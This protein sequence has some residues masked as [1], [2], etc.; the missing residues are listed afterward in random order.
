MGKDTGSDA[1]VVL[2]EEIDKDYEPTEQEIIDY[3]EWLGMDPQ[4]DKDLL[5]IAKAGLKAP[6]PRPWKP[7]QTNE[8]GEIFYFNFETGESVWDHPCDEYHRQL[9]QKEKAKKYG[10][11]LPEGAPDSPTS[12]SASGSLGNSLS[13]SQG[14]SLDEEG[15]KK[16]KKDKKEKKEKKDKKDKKEKKEALQAPKELAPLAISGKAAGVG[17]GL[18]FGRRE[19]DMDLESSLE[20]SLEPDEVKSSEFDEQKSN[21][22][23]V[24]EDEMDGIDEPPKSLEEV[25]GGSLGVG[26]LSG[27][28]LQPVIE[29]D[30][31]DEDA[32]S[33]VDAGESTPK[34]ADG[35]ATKSDDSAS[36]LRRS[37]SKQRSKEELKEEAQEGEAAPAS[38]DS[39]K[40]REELEA[41][42][43]ERLQSQLKDFIE[44]ETA[45]YEEEREKKRTSLQAENK[46]KLERYRK[47]MREEFE[48]EREKAFTELQDKH[49]KQL[50]E[51]RQ[52][53]QQQLVTKRQ[54]MK[55]GVEKEAADMGKME[56]RAR[57]AEAERD[58]LNKELDEL[59]SQSSGDMAEVQRRMEKAESERAASQKEVEDLR[60]RVR[61]LD[62]DFGLSKNELAASAKEV[63]TLQEQL[64]AKIEECNKLQAAES[65]KAD[66]VSSEEVKNLQA[67]LD[68]KSEEAEWLKAEAAA[69]AER[70]AKEVEDSLHDRLMAQ[71]QVEQL[72][73]RLSQAT[74]EAADSRSELESKIRE[75]ERAHTETTASASALEEN[76]RLQARL[77]EEQEKAQ[78]SI[79]SAK[80]ELEREKEKHLKELEKVN[81]DMEAASQE[82]KAAKAELEEKKSECQRLEDTLSQQAQQTQIQLEGMSREVEIAASEAAKG[83]AER[84][85]ATQAQVDQLS[86]ELESLR[87]ESKRHQD[88]SSQ[89]ETERDTE[90]AS[91]ARSQEE[92]R[93]TL[94]RA[95][96]EADGMH[97]I[98]VRELSADIERLRADI[99]R[100]Q[101]QRERAEAERDARAKECEQL[102]DQ[103]TKS[104]LSKQEHVVLQTRLERDLQTVQTQLEQERSA[105][106]RAKEDGHS[107]SVELSCAKMELEAKVAE[108]QRLRDTAAESSRSAADGLSNIQDRLEQECKASTQAR[109]ELAATSRE[110]AVMRAELD[111]RTG[112]VERLHAKA[113]EGTSRSREEVQ[114][115]Q[116]QLGEERGAAVQAR[117]EMQAAT[118]ELSVLKA[119]LDMR[120]KECE[121]LQS[122]SLES[123]RASHDEVQRMQRQLTEERSTAAQSQAQLA[124]QARDT[125]ILRAE[126]DASSNECKRLQDRLAESSGI[127]VEELKHAQSQLDEE[128][129]RSN[130]MRSEVATVSCEVASLR[131]ELESKTVECARLR[132][133]VS[134]GSGATSEEVRRLRNQLDEERDTVTQMRIA[135]SVRVKSEAAGGSS[136]FAE[137]VRRLK[138]Q[139]EEERESVTRYQAEA[140]SA[141]VR[142]SAESAAL[143]AELD[144]RSA[145]CGRLRA[146]LLR[147][148]AAA[149]NQAE[150]RELAAL[151]AQVADQRAEAEQLRR[152]V[153][154]SPATPPEE[155]RT[156]RA[157]IKEREDSILQLKEQA[158]QASA[159]HSEEVDRLR[160]RLADVRAEEQ[161]RQTE[162]RESQ[163]A[164]LQA[165]LRSRASEVERLHSEVRN[166]TSEVERLK[167]EARNA[168][169]RASASEAGIVEATKAAAAES[170]RREVKRLE[171]TL[172]ERDGDLY[173]ARDQVERLQREVRRLEADEHRATQRADAVRTDLEQ[174]RQEAQ[175]FRE[176]VTEAER[177]LE[178]ARTSLR[179]EHTGRA[180]AEGNVRDA[181]REL[182]A[183]RDQLQQQVAENELISAEARRYRNELADRESESTRMQQHILGR[184]AE[185]RQLRTSSE[186]QSQQSESAV[187][188][189]W[190]QIGER[191]LAVKDREQV[192]EERE[193]LVAEAEA[194]ILERRR[195]LRAELQQLELANLQAAVSEFA[196]PSSTGRRGT[197]TPRSGGPSRRNSASPPPVRHS[198]DLL[199]GAHAGAPAAASGA[200][201]DTIVL[202]APALGAEGAADVGNDA[203]VAST[204]FNA[205]DQP[206]RRLSPGPAVSSDEAG[207]TADG[208]EGHGRGGASNRFASPRGDDRAAVG[209]AVIGLDA[210]RRELRRERAALEDLRRQWKL[211]LQK[212]QVSGGNAQAH[213]VLA[214]VRDALGERALALN[215]AIDDHRAL[216]RALSARKRDRLAGD[217]DCIEGG[218]PRAFVKP[219][220]DTGGVVTP[221]AGAST[222]LH[223]EEVDIMRRWQ[224]LLSPDAAGYGRPRSARGSILGLSPR[225][226]TADRHLASWGRRTR[227]SRDMIDHH[228]QWLRGFQRDVTSSRPASARAHYRW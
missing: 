166:W 82:C 203:E 197:D 134:D 131:A 38:Q 146:E 94:A 83:P 227:T 140:A 179:G 40:L 145:E 223:G 23:E 34:A 144:A 42:E 206:L 93:A 35:I 32:D 115:L 171:D 147:L 129:R 47:E 64:D 138:A 117:A 79:S 125:A 199:P 56:Q 133:E 84:L 156:L 160:N 39:A 142:A 183:L 149:P 135:E 113:T 108:C 72:E 104:A 165:Q 119:E 191:E 201:P 218:A 193:R 196:V 28:A 176:D 219:R 36:Q 58:R 46:T 118:R 151:R 33:K 73:E 11:P 76:Q 21:N 68:A 1:A 48:F 19:R 2:E 116:M 216:E 59:K 74:K 143:T 121:R 195:E 181:Q 100:H 123:T 92:Q 182:R 106:A 98:Q 215:R 29:D 37:V 209:D 150:V 50:R 189:S 44:A 110:L 190:N 224:T 202:A 175:Q 157:A 220:A 173:T 213:A 112:E 136:A 13:A 80:E 212:L 43:R 126:L 86:A 214:D 120:T 186:V 20:E 172:R 162:A 52:T 25:L 163:L 198:G 31:P 45:K 65:S 5:W 77:S 159:A 67:Q 89:L 105:L 194:V 97:S 26:S 158:A 127:T 185:L 22:S 204:A 88:R 24:P 91:L 211:D 221:R 122:K 178:D 208:A 55:E 210:R 148:E 95:R 8:E 69:T 54:E 18:V 128:R 51:D 78:S 192:L 75:H 132:T 207:D 7:C 217:A 30:E 164:D 225:T 152:Q 139:L 17:S 87:A 184:E 6:L 90:R 168:E 222:L 154:R 103:S 10:L 63:R 16:E 107:R 155:E 187:R 61:N 9:F 169:S 124:S 12:A 114:S 49:D 62:D 57:D 96:E 60:K 27:S 188:R 70:D 14:A 180:L 71:K 15:K 99:L 200:T 167:C 66:W 109:A 4:K 228:L 102:R 226:S 205:M 41:K 170:H 53:L 153:A 3:A 101:E 137:D 85:A 174:A 81:S 111:A 130:Q 177:R 161:R 141:T